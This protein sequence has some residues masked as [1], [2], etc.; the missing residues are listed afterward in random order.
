MLQ[1]FPITAKGRMWTKAQTLV[2]SPMLEL[3]TMAC[4]CWKNVMDGISIEH[5]ARSNEEVRPALRVLESTPS[6]PS[7]DAE[8]QAVQRSEE[9][10][11]QH[12]RRVTCDGDPAAELCSQHHEGGHHA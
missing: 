7:D 6:V 2:P 8:A 11:E 4:V 12:R 9:R 3:S 5:G 1:S 10:D